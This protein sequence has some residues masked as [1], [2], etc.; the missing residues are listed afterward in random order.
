[1]ENRYNE[2]SLSN[3]SIEMFDMLKKEVDLALESK[4][5][6][7][8]NDSLAKSSD[9]NQKLEQNQHIQNLNTINPN[10]QTILPNP[11]DSAQTA[12]KSQSAQSNQ[13]SSSDSHKR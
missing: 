5:A 11:N 13:K 10:I 3:Q 9:S 2:V 6:Q 8:Q 4:Q 7:I 1:M 12:Q